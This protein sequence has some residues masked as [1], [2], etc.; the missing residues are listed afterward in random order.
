MSST[1]M[2]RELNRLDAEI[3]R[4]EAE[5]KRLRKQVQNVRAAARGFLWAISVANGSGEG[6]DLR[7]EKL[8][9]LRAALADQP[10]EETELDRQ[11]RETDVPGDDEMQGDQLTDMSNVKD[12]WNDEEKA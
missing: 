5:N 7:E 9:E 10:A 2:D 3:E 6:P 12:E 4:L 11:L 1:E 8:D